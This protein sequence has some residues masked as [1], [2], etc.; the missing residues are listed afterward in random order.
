MINRN[1]QTKRIQLR[2]LSNVPSSRITKDGGCS[3][4]LNFQCDDGGDLVPMLKPTLADLGLPAAGISGKVLFIH[5]QPSYTNVIGYSDG[6]GSCTI[7][8]YSQGEALNIDSP[9]VTFTP[10]SC[11]SV[12]N[13]IIVSG[14]PMEGNDSGTA[15]YLYK[16][17]GGE[18]K[19]KYLGD[20]IPVPELKFAPE[21]MQAEDYETWSALTE[22]EKRARSIGSISHHVP[23]GGA[24]A[25]Y[26]LFSLG[27]LPVVIRA[28]ADAPESD[29]ELATIVR[30][31]GLYKFSNWAYGAK[32]EVIYDSIKSIVDRTWA[33]IEELINY[34][35]SRG[36]LNM[37]VFIRYAIRMY[38]GTCY[39]VSIPILV[40]PQDEDGSKD[41]IKVE[42]QHCGN[43]HGTSGSGTDPDYTEY[44]ALGAYE[45]TMNYFLK[46][47]AKSSTSAF[48][49]W[50]DLIESI[51]I[52]ATRM[53]TPYPDKTKVRPDESSVTHS[54]ERLLS[55]DNDFYTRYYANVGL[56]PWGLADEK[57][58]EKNIL[59]YSNFYLI[60]SY[61]LDEFK[62]IQS[63]LW[64]SLQDE[65]NMD[66][67]HLSVLETLNEKDAYQSE[68][69]LLTFESSSYNKRVLAW[70]VSQKLSQGYP[71]AH[72]SLIN[73]QPNQYEI[74]YHINTGEGVER[75]VYGGII[76]DE[77]WYSW[78]AYPDSRCTKVTFKWHN[79]TALYEFDLGTI[80]MKP[81]PSLN[82][83]YAFCGLDYRLVGVEHFFVETDTEPNDD[84]IEHITGQIMQS[85]FS[86]PWSFPAAGRVSVGDGN[87]IGVGIIAKPLSSGQFG[88][89]D[90][91]AFTDEGIWALSSNS[92]GLLTTAKPL[93][94]DVAYPGSI[95]TL[96]QSVAFITDKGVMM[97]A[98]GD[99]TCISESLYGKSDTPS[100]LP[101][102]INSAMD[103]AWAGILSTQ[104]ADVTPFMLFVKNAKI[105]YDYAG[106]RLLVYNPTAPFMYV[107]K[108]G[109][110]TW[111]RMD[112]S[113]FTGYPENALNSYPD[114]D[115]VCTDPD[116]GIRKIWDFSSYLYETEGQETLPGA[117]VTRPL[118]LDMIDSYKSIPHLQLRHETEEDSVVKYM[119]I[120]SDDLR[121]WRQL[122]S[123]KG[124]SHKYFRIAVVANMAPSDRFDYIELDFQPKFLGKI[125]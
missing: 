41:I 90:L 28:S 32:N 21:G 79:P 113:A 45:L 87:V 74:W 103:E 69:R 15:Y 115:I 120:A 75:V 77:T 93:T 84:S 92:E 16:E 55:G 99:V 76:D 98:G 30:D 61:T 23:A 106:R 65:M 122:H 104:M 71:L 22:E 40:S 89:F 38:D 68:H 107:Y 3:E 14:E 66:P 42:I 17:D 24:V 35:S 96:D 9:S 105:A 34:N 39:G 52:F 109:P 51:D 6:E 108:F 46:F 97:L 73:P 18:K 72:S 110:S 121:T 44:I 112:S 50:D 119:L 57:E 124:P 43:Q 123:L 125:R 7:L 37:P 59:G 19:Y 4:S 13:T 53:I 111:H 117:V 62:K 31:Q 118:N 11:T 48:D 56:D 102:A 54:S 63:N 100:W 80:K 49:G 10:K 26:K 12:G 83:A 70:D 91:Y 82:I 36:V 81:H 5:K 8:A 88:Q 60:K 78:I 33:Q 47:M 95:T 101:T 64:I 1:T 27:T 86:N 20:H 29:R 58:Q 114:C 85:Q 94:R 2:G 67:D 25:A 116:T